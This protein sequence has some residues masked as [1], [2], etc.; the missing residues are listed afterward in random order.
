MRFLL[1]AGLGPYTMGSKSLDGTLFADSVAPELHSTYERLLGD[2]LRFDQLISETTGFPLLR[3]YRGSMPDL[4]TATVR[5]VIEDSGV[6]CEVLELRALWDAGTQAPEPIDLVGLSTSFICDGH[7]LSAAIDWVS[8]HY[9]SVPLVLG[10]QHSNIKYREILAA[11]PEV[12]FII[13]G[14]AEAALPLLLRAL[15]NNQSLDRIPNLVARRHDGSLHI[16]PLDYVKL[17][18]IR[19]P[20]FVGQQRIL[21]YESM[22]G[23]PFSCKY[24]SY[25]SASPQWRFRSAE[26]IVRDWSEYADVNGTELIR[27]MDST[28][29]IPRQRFR[30]LLSILPDVGVRWEAYTR[31]NVIDSPRVVEQLANAQCDWL[32]I[33][34]ESMS[35][36]TLQAMDK[37]VTAAQ[38][39]RA[40]AVMKDSPIALRTSFMVGFPGE[41]PED[42]EL[43]HRFIVERLT[44]RFGVHVFAFVDETMPVWA[45]AERHQLHVKGPLKWKHRGMNAA[46]AAELRE[47]TLRDARWTSDEAV[48]SL[49]QLG[50]ERP[51]MPERDDQHNRRV[52]KQLERLGF[53]VKDFGESAESEKRSRQAAAELQRLG[54]RWGVPERIRRDRAEPVAIN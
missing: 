32:L 46:T 30:Q 33:G 12:D 36:R 11:H 4:P 1:I 42:Y 5:G 15:E 18:D 51:L 41:T 43:T 47:Q 45:D 25:P 6:E 29:T 52:E 26:Q 31:A 38:N 54:V 39:E 2:P 35:D 50:Y 8:D 10:G 27:A 7:T 37:R 34:F 24:C 53:V 21:P 16:A 3:P 44:G 49:W 14:D 28:F 48:L 22:R 13:R 40:F 20:S 9:P 17:D 19:R 23:C